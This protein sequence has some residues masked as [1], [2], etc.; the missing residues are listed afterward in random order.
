MYALLIIIGA[1]GLFMY[2]MKTLSTGLQKVA[3]ESLRNFIERV[4]I[5]RFAS[6]TT[7][8]I[9]TT[10]I[11]SSTATTVMI[12]GFVNAGLM[13]LFQAIGVTLGAHIGTTIKALIIAYSGSRL[14]LDNLA[15]FFA[16]LSFPILF[17]RKS[18]L[19]AFAEFMMGLSIVFL[20][21]KLLQGSADELSQNEYFMDMIKSFSGRGFGSMTFALLVAMA[22]TMIV[23]SSSAMM[24]LTIVLCQ[25]QV[26]SFEM[27]AAMVIG[28]NIGTTITANIAAIVANTNAKRAALAHTLIKIFGAIWIFPVFGL[29]LNLLDQS[30]QQ[31]TVH[32]SPFYDAAAR[33]YALAFLH[34]GFNVVNVLLVIGFIPQVEK[35]TRMIIKDK[36]G[37]KEEFKLAYIHSGL[38]KSPE[39]AILEAKKGI[40]KLGEIT[41]KMF[42]LSQ[43]LLTRNEGVEFYDNLD[44]IEK[45]EKLTDDIEIEITNYLNKISEHEISHET[46]DNLRKMINITN[47]LERLADTFYQISKVMEHKLVEKIWFTPEQR[48]NIREMFTHIDRAFEIMH[49]NLVA[50][51]G[52]INLE[53]ARELENNINEWRNK[54]KAEHLASIQNRDYNV[55]SSSVYSD[56]YSYYE[57]AGD[58]IFNVSK[59][60]A[61]EI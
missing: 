15:L 60:V 33:P 46:A 42:V 37:V 10:I 31:F 30:V 43:T 17:A 44:K 41:R 18:K 52:A 53:K 56:L 19:K 12:V 21:L 51:N 36:S 24:V 25:K 49:S 20:S 2:G 8:L 57:K 6:T 29:V 26:I 54:L 27:A 4:T 39:I 1:M 14:N 22:F 34:V 28:E 45:Y 40:E 13:N 32:G 55:K 61:G 16:A 59:A 38:I 7:G 23:Q 47:E 35:I 5:N 11:Q 50:D 9:I 58:Q 3:G 48:N